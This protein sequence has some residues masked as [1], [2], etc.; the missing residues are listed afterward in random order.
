MKGVQNMIYKI[1]CGG[2][3]YDEQ[4]FDFVPSPE[5]RTPMFIPTVNLMKRG[6]KELVLASST[7]DSIKNFKITVDDTGTI[8]A[9]EM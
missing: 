4:Y 5:Q 7:P 1:P 8:K 2:F 3:A 9:T 6:D